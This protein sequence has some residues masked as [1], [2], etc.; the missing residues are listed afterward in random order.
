[1]S[2]IKKNDYSKVDPKK[3]ISFGQFNLLSVRFSC[4]GFKARKD[5]D[6][7]KVDWSRQKQIRGCLY[8]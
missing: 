2:T 1:M 6:D 7:S 3:L 8:A 5:N 4:K